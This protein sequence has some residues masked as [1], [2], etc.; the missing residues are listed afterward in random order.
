MASNHREFI[1]QYQEADRQ[2]PQAKHRQEPQNATKQERY[3]YGD[4]QR[5]RTRQREVS[6]E[7]GY[8]VLSLARLAVGIHALHCSVHPCPYTSRLSP[9]PKGQFASVGAR[10]DGVGLRL[11]E[12]ATEKPFKKI[13]FP[14]CKAEKDRYSHPRS[15]KSAVP[16]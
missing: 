11:R 9:A 6:P 14:L 3:A 2:H 13:E 15:H 12:R 16:R 10:Y 8:L 7:G 5:T 1:G 4:A